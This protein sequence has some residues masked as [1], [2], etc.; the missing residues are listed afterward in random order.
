MKVISKI[1]GFVT[2][3]VIAGAVASSASALTSADIQLLV[4][5]GVIPA[6]KA[7]AAMAVADNNVAVGNATGSC[8]FTYTRNLTLGSTGADVVALQTYLEGK[9]TLVIP[10]GV[11]KGYFGPL[12]R[13]ALASYQASAG[14]APAVGYFGPITMGRVTADCVVTGGGD[15]NNGGNNA[16]LKGG[17][18]SL[19]DYDRDSKYTNEDLEEGDTAM[20]FGAEFDVEDGDARIER[21]DVQVQAATANV[22]D[23]PWKQI[24]SI[25]LYINGEMVDEMDVDDEDDWSE[26]NG[27]S[28]LSTNDAYEIRFSGLSEVVREDETAEI[29]IEI[30]ASDRIDD[31]DLDST[32][33]IFIP[34]NGIRAIDGEGID[35]Y[36]GDEDEVTE[37]TI[38]AADDGDLS[39]RESDDDPDSA[40]LIVDED[41][42]SVDYEV[43]RF[44]INNEDAD[45]FLNE[46]TI[47]A[48]TSDDD[49]DDVISQL[50]VMIDGEEF[51]YDTASTSA[52]IGE[53]VFEFE[54]ND[55]EIPVEEDEDI[56]VVVMVEFNQTGSNGSNYAEGTSIQFGIGRIDGANYGADF[57]L[58]EGQQSGDATTVSG[59]Q[60]S[61]THVLRIEGIVAEGV[62][63][64]ATV[65]KP[66]LVTQEETGV[67]EIEVQLTALEDDAWIPAYVAQTA[68]TTAG[69][70]FEITGDTFAGNVVQAFISDDSTDTRTNN[71]LKISEGSSERFTVYVELDP[72][73]TG[74]YGIELK[75]I[76]FSSTSAG[77]LVEYDVPNESEFETK[78][79]PVNAD[80]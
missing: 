4:S 1:S 11:S 52:G 6:D 58:A 18:A 19:T 77:T 60:E 69:F 14:I 9:G 12:T 31:G 73:A 20:V 44:E 36:T 7:A 16:D 27:V 59:Q 79:V 32:W 13:S 62:S 47:I 56:E 70:T 21:I 50:M 57:L 17:E 3:L 66:D 54:D 29:E 35:Q 8:G 74:S 51:D 26:E 33:S 72:S 22:E 64:S 76:N 71:R 34:E 39:I 80:N 28:S 2:T 67:F 10:A 46:M 63:K 38:E 42:D 43:F 75:E 78:R 40:I 48:S 37:F 55:D 68:S 23:E 45:I 24:E 65:D 25:A 15:N 49:I 5:L 30:T 61:S 41:D 53:F